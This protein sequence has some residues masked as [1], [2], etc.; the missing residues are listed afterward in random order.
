MVFVFVIAIFLSAA[1]LF[2]VQPMVGRLVLPAMG[3]S[4]AVWNTV[5]VF[6]QLALLTGYALA[7]MIAK[8]KRSRNQVLAHAIIVILALLLLPIGVAARELAESQ[9]PALA[10]FARLTLDLGPIALALAIMSPIL[11]HWYAAM[12]LPRREDP[13]FL[14]AASNA[15]SLIGLL[16]YP[17]LI[18]PT[19]GLAQ[20]R[21]LWS[22]GFGVLAIT[23]LIVW[24]GVA[25]A[26][27]SAVT[28][29]ECTKPAEHTGRPIQWIVLAL[30][31]SS[32]LLGVTQHITTDI[33]AVPLLWVIPLA[34]YLITFIVAF[35]V[36]TNRLLRVLTRL[37]PVLAVAAAVAFMVDA[38]HPLIVVVALH[39]VSFMAIALACHARLAQSRPPADQLTRFYLFV[40]IGGVMGGSINAL[41]APVV[42]SWVAEYPIMIALGAGLAVGWPKFSKR[43]LL[44]ALPALVLAFVLIVA[45]LTIPSDWPYASA[46]L[47]GV[48]ALAC[49][50][51]S[52]KPARFALALLVAL[53]LPEVIRPSEHIVH[54]TRTFF[55]VHTVLHEDA[56]RGPRHTLRHGG[57]LHGLQNLGSAESQTYYHT[58]GPIGEVFRSLPAHADIGAIGLGVGS[59]AALARKGDTLTFHEIDPAVVRIASDPALFT[60][61]TKSPA[62]I[63]YVLGDGRLT[64]E[65]AEPKDLIIVDAFTSDAIP[66]HL[67]TAEA[68]TLYAEHLKPGGVLALH[69]SNR[70]LDLAPVIAATAQK[71]GLAGRI[72]TDIPNT[73]QINDGKEISTWAVLAKDPDSLAP[74]ENWDPLATDPAVRAWTDDYANILDVLML[75]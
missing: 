6:F 14:Y 37:V 22:I 17:L 13:Y 54:R 43:T 31:P 44:D 1:L 51:C 4:P 55:G 3:G 32:L 25:R 11:Q 7:H 64:I 35:A 2:A 45:M 40:S 27:R 70:Y 67:L 39:L 5:M 66:V 56:A 12:N 36:R 30:V 75:D 53:L 18:E 48:P 34:L 68:L 28:T 19:L 61:T 21:T 47:I 9:S 20:Q 46:V 62:T 26:P 50:L 52:T 58:T 24:I 69:L 16:G 10:L 73:T 15:G 74:F 72:R 60:Y 8:L 38:R 23:T 71:A 63:R 57:T 42:L 41:L 59:V 29:S 49:F 65:S 33:A